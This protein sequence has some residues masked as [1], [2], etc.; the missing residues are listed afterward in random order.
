MYGEEVYLEDPIPNFEQ[1]WHGRFFIDDPVR[2]IVQLAE[3]YETK[4]EAMS[5]LRELMAH[6]ST[7]KVG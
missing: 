1:R 3:T 6:Y 7:Q 2:H 5:A 4:Q